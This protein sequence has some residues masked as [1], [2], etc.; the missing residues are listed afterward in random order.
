MDRRTRLMGHMVEYLDQGIDQIGMTWRS[1]RGYFPNEFKI[2]KPPTFDGGMKKLEDAEVWLLGMKKFFVLHD[3]K[4]NIKFGIVIFSIKGKEYIWW[5]DVKLD[6]AIKTEELSWHEFKRLFKEKYLLEIYYDGKAK[7][8]YELKMGPMTYEEYITNFL[9]LLR[10]V[11]DLKYENT[12]V[13]SFISEMPL[14]FKDQIEEN[15]PPSL[16]EIIG[17]LKHC[18]E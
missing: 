3:Y 17:K 8:F 14:A 12:K 6:R 18:Y 11:S 5:D 13:Q 10:Y 2:T 7:E 15:E 1:D 4:K 16:E 9:E